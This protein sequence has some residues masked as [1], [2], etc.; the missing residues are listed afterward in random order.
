MKRRRP[1]NEQLM[2]IARFFSAWT[3]I[4]ALFCLPAFASSVQVK[5]TLVDVIAPGAAS[6]VKLRNQGTTPETVQIRIFRWTQTNDQDTLATTQDVVASPPAVT[7]APNTD[8]VA[9]VVRVSKQ[10][11]VGEEAYRM[12]VDVLP[13]SARSRSGVVEF[14]GTPVDPCLLRLA[15]TNAARGRLDDRQT[16]PAPLP[17]RAQ[18]GQLAPAYLGAFSQR[19]AR[20]QGLVRGRP[21]RLRAWPLEHALAG[22]C[23]SRETQPQ[24]RHIDFRAGQ[25]GRNPCDCRG[26][27]GSIGSTHVW[28]ACWVRSSSSSKPAKPRWQPKRF[29]WKCSSTAFPPTR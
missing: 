17:D 19:R 14:P 29:N 25:W 2:S 4:L 1:P 28:L 11:V 12:L 10:P 26:S 18:Q 22:A 16:G 13:D 21:G 6:I 24:G 8:Y 20:Q 7:L 27:R 5:P 23:R 3:T 15:G 9:R